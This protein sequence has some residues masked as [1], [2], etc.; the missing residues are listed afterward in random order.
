M[1]N[2]V[3]LEDI[4]VDFAL[5]PCLRFDMRRFLQFKRNPITLKQS[6]SIHL[7]ALVIDSIPQ[8]SREEALTIHFGS[9]RV[10]RNSILL[11]YDESQ[12]L[13]IAPPS[14]CT[15]GNTYATLE[16]IHLINRHECFDDVGRELKREGG[17]EVRCFGFVRLGSSA[18]WHR[19]GLSV[20]E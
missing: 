15:I 17:C 14:S 11:R 7:T 3:Q 13:V 16:D 1:M 4:K 6:Y 8:K 18:Q 20:V 9:S 12:L 10:S 5:I 19:C 2:V